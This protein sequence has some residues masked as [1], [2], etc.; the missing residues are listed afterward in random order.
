MPV[1]KIIASTKQVEVKPV[2]LKMARIIPEPTASN[3]SPG[4]APKKLIVGPIRRGQ[5]VF[6]TPPIRAGYNIFSNNKVL[7]IALILI[8]IAILTVPI[9]WLEP[10]TAQL[11][12]MFVS[13]G[14]QWEKK[15]LMVLAKDVKAHLHEVELIGQKGDTGL[16]NLDGEKTLDWKVLSGARLSDKNDEKPRRPYRIYLSTEGQFVEVKK[17]DIPVFFE[18]GVKELTPSIVTSNKLRAKAG[19][20][21]N[22]LMRPPKSHKGSMLVNLYMFQEWCAFDIE[23]VFNNGE[24]VQFNVPA[25]DP[26]VIHIPIEI[27]NTKVGKFYQIKITASKDTTGDF[28]MGLNAVHVEGR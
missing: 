16:V 7:P 17:K 10:V 8:L 2:S 14:A 27:P 26:G 24:A 20:G 1:A 4:S 22:I 5:T 13:G 6:G 3:H 25:L 19:N 23:V 18:V 11:R 15:K 21:W 28:S 12:S 9:K